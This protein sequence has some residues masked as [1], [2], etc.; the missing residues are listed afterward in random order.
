MGHP[1]GLEE[2]VSFNVEALSLRPLQHPERFMSLNNLG[3]LLCLGFHEQDEAMDSD[4]AIGYH[5]EAFSLYASGHVGRVT[6]LASPAIALRYRTEQV[7]G[8]GNL[9][10]AVQ[11]HLGAI[12]LFLHG[13]GG[14]S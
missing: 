8:I 9:N 5:S 7:G 2:T 14:V 10:H 13:H 1:K 4:K 11:F 3:H 12:P 6:S